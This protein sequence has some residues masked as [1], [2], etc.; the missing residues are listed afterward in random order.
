MK[1][2]TRT[3]VCRLEEI[4]ATVQ[5]IVAENQR[6]RIDASNDGQIGLVDVKLAAMSNEHGRFVVCVLLGNL[7]YEG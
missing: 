4:D 6:D 3:R 7:R 5:A 2:F 1:R